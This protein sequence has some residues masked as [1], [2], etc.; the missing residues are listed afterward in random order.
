MKLA[1]PC[2][3]PNASANL[4]DYVAAVEPEAPRLHAAVAVV[5]TFIGG[6]SIGTVGA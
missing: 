5:A 4:A 3:T 6:E 2:S 1:C